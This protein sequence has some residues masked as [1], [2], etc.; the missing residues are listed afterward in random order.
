[1]RQFKENIASAAQTVQIADHLSNVHERFLREIPIK[2]NGK[3]SLSHK[4][5]W[6]LFMN[7]GSILLFGQNSS[8]SEAQETKTS[9]VT[10]ETYL[11]K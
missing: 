2:V 3:T 9:V 10:I 7:T 6:C 5:C 1:M 11:L 4:P 8:V